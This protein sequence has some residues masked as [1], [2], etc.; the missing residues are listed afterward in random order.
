LGA[1]FVAFRVERLGHQSPS[2]AL[3]EFRELLAKAGHDLVESGDAD[4]H[5]S[6]P[7]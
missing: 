6:I 5:W 4:F 7:L 1:A 2:F 3:A